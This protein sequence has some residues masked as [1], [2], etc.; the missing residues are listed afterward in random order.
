MK[1]TFN[2]CKIYLFKRWQWLY[3]PKYGIYHFGFILF[4]TL[5]KNIEPLK[6][7]NPITKKE[8]IYH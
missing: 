5:P 7:Y 8:E 4:L 6:F 3:A 2:K 1:F